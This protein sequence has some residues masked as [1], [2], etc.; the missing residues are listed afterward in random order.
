MV[1]KVRDKNKDF[2][3]KMVR[4]GLKIFRIKVSE[5]TEKLLVQIFNFGIVGVIATL[6][7]FVFLYLFK[8][9]CNLN[10][11]LANSLSF[12]ISVVYNYWASL[13]FVFNVNKE[14]SQRR[15]FIFFIVGSLVGLL[16][17]DG[18]IWLLTELIFIH[19]LIAKVFATIV[20]MVF[21][22]VTR[23]KFLE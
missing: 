13:M 23:K 3:T 16:I 19:Y 1:K 22:F 12:V 18:I 21:N 5:K 20:V 11:V 6:I 4:L 10:V 2:G 15:N 14:K 8:E 9:Y 17:S 7:D